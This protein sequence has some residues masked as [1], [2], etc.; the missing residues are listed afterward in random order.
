MPLALQSAILKL[1]W[2]PLP[3]NILE[4][5][6]MLIPLL[7]LEPSCPAPTAMVT[8][9]LSPTIVETHHTQCHKHHISLTPIL[10]VKFPQVLHC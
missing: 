7:K 8:C 1:Q 2:V 4:I 5:M 9:S 10:I 3:A 6:S